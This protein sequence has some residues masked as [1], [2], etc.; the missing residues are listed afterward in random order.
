MKA[1]LSLTLL[2]W[3]ISGHTKATNI[4]GNAYGPYAIRVETENP[5]LESQLGWVRYFVI[6]NGDSYS[7]RIENRKSVVSC[8]VTLLTGKQGIFIV[9]GNNW[10]EVRG[11]TVPLG[12][13]KCYKVLEV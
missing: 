2:I 3:A 4:F 13:I 5:V 9:P 10:L 7:L 12:D 11:F 6:D 8:K 1:L